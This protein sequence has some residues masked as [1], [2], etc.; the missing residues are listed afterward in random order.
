MIDNVSH[1]SVSRLVA[2][3]SM[4]LDT[5]SDKAFE[6][7]DCMSAILSCQVRITIMNQ[8]NALSNRVE[9]READH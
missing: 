1:A 2:D 7:I 9:Y 3:N 4:C 8:L 5:A 6:N